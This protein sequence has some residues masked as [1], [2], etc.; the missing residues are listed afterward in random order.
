[1]DEEDT[2][3]LQIVPAA[4][5]WRLV[6][7]YAEPTKEDQGWEA[8]PIAC[9]VLV[10]WN[11][12]RTA[13]RP[14]TD[15]SI[16]HLDESWHDVRRYRWEVIGPDKGDGW[17]EERLRELVDVYWQAGSDGSKGPPSPDDDE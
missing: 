1:M 11:D 5:G 10:R 8:W 6:S 2:T 14:V 16:T 12:G 13:L 7:F 3:I 4:K 9:W 17:I 15:D